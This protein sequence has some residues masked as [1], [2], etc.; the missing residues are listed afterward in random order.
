M[1]RLHH[2]VLLLAAFALCAFGANAQPYPNRPIRLIVADAAGGAPDQLGRLVA[3]KLS[4]TE[5]VELKRRLHARLPAAATGEITVHSWATA[6][7][8]RK[9]S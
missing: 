4:D 2:G 1:K 7:K 5:S 3:Q 6:I 9:A 8:G